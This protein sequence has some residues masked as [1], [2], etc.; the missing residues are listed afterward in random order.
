HD[1]YFLDRCVN[2]IYEI[3]PGGFYRYEGTFSVYLETKAAR[4]EEQTRLE[5]KA[6]NFLRKEMEWL[7]RQPKARGTKQKARIDR[8]EQVLERT[9]FRLEEEVEFSVSGRRLGK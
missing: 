9:P 8:I 6:Q 3:D 7:G 5:Q 4:V 1:R 2:R